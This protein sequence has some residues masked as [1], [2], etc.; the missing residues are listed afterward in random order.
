MTNIF[1]EIKNLFTLDVVKYNPVI[2]AWAL[3]GGLAVLLGNLVGISPTQEAA[4]TVILTGLVAIFTM[5]MTKEFVVSS[6]TGIL[7]TIAV[8]AAAFGLHLSSAEIGAGVALIGGVLALMLRQNLTP[9][10]RPKLTVV[11]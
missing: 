8:A 11:R 3:N 4:V 7:T 9:A 5:V 2:L 1:T 6:F 10:A